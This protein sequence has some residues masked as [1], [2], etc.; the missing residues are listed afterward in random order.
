MLLGSRSKK[1]SN[2]NKVFIKVVK[3]KDGCT[4]IVG[5]SFVAFL[6]LL[7]ATLGGARL[8]VPSRALSQVVRYFLISRPAPQ[9]HPAKSEDRAERKVNHL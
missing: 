5:R 1:D 4:V 8:S 2:D 3:T 9:V 6:M 7:V